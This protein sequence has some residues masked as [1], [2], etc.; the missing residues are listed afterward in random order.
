M[1]Y[2]VIRFETNK[3]DWLIFKHPVD[4]F[5]NKS[6]LIVSPGQMAFIVHNGKLEKAVENGTFK[7]NSE[8]LPFISGLV[9]AVHFGKNAYPIEIYFVNK[10]IKL[11]FLWGTSD[12]INLMDPKYNVPIRIRAR[13]QLGIKIENNIYFLENLV[14][15]LMKGNGL[16][17]DILSNFFKSLINQKI[18]D[19]ISS[20]IVGNKVCFFD[21]PT[22]MNEISERFESALRPELE[23]LGFS[24]FNLNI[25]SINTPEEDLEKLN[26]ILHKK[27]EYEQLGDST[28]RI[29][30]GYDVLEKGAENNSMAGSILGVGMGLNMG[31]NITGGAI[32]PQEQ[33]K[34]FKCFNCNCEISEKTKFC[35]ECGSKTN[36]KCPNCGCNITSK[37][38]FCPECGNKIGGK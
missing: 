15:T 25:E 10:R 21:V 7:L 18:R 8:F 30:R 34:T 27:A 3:L 29:T 5:N 13:G 19:V 28:Y 33:K 9:N 11:D 31:Q 4:Q 17:F 14:G 6:K 22:H 37:T 35:P 2:D 36:D 32:I 24:I 38:K 20:Y 16:T 26:V 12:P 23:K 1:I